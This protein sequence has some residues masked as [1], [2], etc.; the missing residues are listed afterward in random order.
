M[1]NF[2]NIQYIEK[3]SQNYINDLLNIKILNNLSKDDE[4]SSKLGSIPTQTTIKSKLLNMDSLDKKLSKN[5]K[6]SKALENIYKSKTI[7][8]TFLGKDI[9]SNRLSSYD[10]LSR[11]LRKFND[12]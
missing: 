7:K 3:K 6:L 9:L 12:D 10:E 2:K 1:R 5:D 4:L 11:I 8:S